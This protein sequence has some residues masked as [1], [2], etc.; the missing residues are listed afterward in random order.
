MTISLIAEVAWCL[1]I[2]ALIPLPIRAE[3]GRIIFSGSIVEPTCSLAPE[4][5]AMVTGA[6]PSVVGETRRQTCAR[7][8]HATAAASGIYALTFVRLSSSVPDR[9][10]QY[11]DT[12]V[13]ASRVDAVDP[14][15][16]TQT[17]E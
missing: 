16:I 12:Y 17:Y 13:K 6:T 11:F 15:L 4:E 10:L 5:S 9:V 14:M 8:G 2:I 7:P 1:C 3:S